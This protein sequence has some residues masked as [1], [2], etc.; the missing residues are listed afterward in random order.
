MQVLVVNPGSTTTKLAI[1]SLSGP[2]AEKT[3]THKTK[4]LD[5][6]PD[7]PSQLAAR[8]DDVSSA[9]REAGTNLSRIS[10][11]VARGG[12]IR[13]V[14]PGIYQ[15]N[16]RMLEDLR[17]QVQGP[18]ASNLGGLIA[19]AIAGEMGIPAY[20]VDPVSCDQFHPFSRIN[21]NVSNERNP[22]PYH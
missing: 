4:M 14:E 13:P 2:L 7:V 6:F 3:I 11:V 21:P 15:V 18:H 5:A 20:V 10:A 16:L 17:A 19:D 22:I 8:L 9:L 1:Y 12:L